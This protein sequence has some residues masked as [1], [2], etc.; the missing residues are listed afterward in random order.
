MKDVA[1]RAVIWANLPGHGHTIAAACAK[2]GVTQS[3][4]RKARKAFGGRVTFDEHEL[5]LAGLSGGTSVSVGSMIQYFDWIN[6]ERV[7]ESEMVARLDAL[8]AQGLAKRAGGGY[9]LTI[10]WP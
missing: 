7:D 4:Y 6:H 9:A 5:L 3:A 10:D 8:V 2:F 1:E